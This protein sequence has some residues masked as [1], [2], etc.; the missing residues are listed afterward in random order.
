MYKQPLAMITVMLMGGCV[1][2]PNTPQELVNT[3]NI[4]ESFCYSEKPSLIQ[5]RVNEYL[6]SCYKTIEG[7]TMLPAGGAFITMP[8]KLE[9]YVVGESIP[10]GKRYSVGN[11][12]GYGFTAEVIN[13]SDACETKLAMYA[14]TRFWRKVFVQTDLA[15]RGE[16]AECTL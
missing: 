7:T 5:G 11:K 9:F 6:S 14:V 15:A 4:S 16:K 8:M 12:H 2:I 3:T 13:E 10:G 1:S